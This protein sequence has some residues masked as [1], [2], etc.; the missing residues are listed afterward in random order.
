MILEEFN[1]IVFITGVVAG[2]A[3]ALILKS[4]TTKNTKKNA[5]SNTNAITIKSLQEEL[6]KKQVVIDNFFSDSN[7]HLLA[8]EKRLAE[9]RSSLSNGASQLS[10]V[11]IAPASPSTPQQ[12]LA[13]EDSLSEPPRDYA[14][15]SDDGQGMLSEKFGLKKQAE[16]TEPKRT[17]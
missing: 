15:K 5:V 10:H 3:I 16:F 8:L 4:I 6:D 11:Q 12:E 9:L 7:D 17:I 2:F 1:I 14:P 13:N